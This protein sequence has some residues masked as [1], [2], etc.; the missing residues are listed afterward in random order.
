LS[1]IRSFLSPCPMGDRT[2]AQM[3]NFDYSSLALGLDTVQ[4]HALIS[5]VSALPEGGELPR[6]PDAE[7]GELTRN[8]LKVWSRLQPFAC[9]AMAIWMQ[10]DNFYDSGWKTAPTK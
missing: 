4:L 1:G 3:A 10:K 8:L 6:D 5:R 7:F 9:R 2:Y